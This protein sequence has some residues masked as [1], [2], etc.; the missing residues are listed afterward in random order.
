MHGRKA[1]FDIQTSILAFLHSKC[2]LKLQLSSWHFNSQ[3]WRFNSL[4]AIWPQF[5]CLL[6]LRASKAS[7]RAILIIIIPFSSSSVKWDEVLYIVYNGESLPVCIHQFVNLTRQLWLAKRNPEKWVSQRYSIPWESIGAFGLTF[8][9]QNTLK[10]A[11]NRC[12]IVNRERN[13]F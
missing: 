1:C 10:N 13:F 4:F 5:W 9:P 6:H 3:H 12:E 11:K 2:I 8:G 7:M